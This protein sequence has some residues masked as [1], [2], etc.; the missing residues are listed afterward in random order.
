[1]TLYMNCL[2]GHGNT[3]TDCRDLS[4]NYLECRMQ[5]F[6]VISRFFFPPE[7][8][9]SENLSRGLMERDDWRNLG[10]SNVDTKGSTS[11]S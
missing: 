7:V 11:K 9:T 1:M 10:L 6:V 2:R 3:S 4:K 8:V 5:K